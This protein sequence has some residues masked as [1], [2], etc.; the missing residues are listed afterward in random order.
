MKAIGLLAASTLG[1][2]LLAHAGVSVANDQDF[3]TKAGQGGMLEVQLGQTAASQGRSE[4]VKG[5]GQRMVAD[6]GKANEGL[7]AAAAADGLIVPPAMSSE[8]EAMMKKLS[9]KQ[10]GAF[11][12][13]YSKDMVK[14]HKEDIKLFEMEAK[15]GTSPRVKAFAEETLPTLR[16]HLKMAEDLVGKDHASKM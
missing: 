4:G 15:S 8:Q 11:D 12:A 5:F 3:V 6:H 9:A 7:N 14:D 16:D 13:A 10:G 1:V 2:V